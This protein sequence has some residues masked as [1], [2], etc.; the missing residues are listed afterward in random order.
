MIS[1]IQKYFQKHFK[2]VFLLILAAMAVPLIVIFTPS[3]G[4]GQGERRV[5]KQDFFGY[6]LGSPEDQ[7]R[8]FGDAQISAMLQLGYSSLSEDQLK[9]YALQRIA[10]LHLANELH[11]PASTKAE[12][13]DFI[14]NLRA[15]SGPDGNFDPQRYASFRDSLKS[16]RGL[17]EADVG[18]IIA[19]DVRAD[20]VRKLLAGPGYVLDADVKAQLARTGT[21]WTLGV[22]TV[23]YASFDPAIKPTSDQLAKFYGD[24]TFRYEV[25]PRVETSAVF[26]PAQNYLSQV[27]ATPEKLKAFFDA[28]PGRF[29]KPAGDA[30]DPK[31]TKPAG[32]GD[33]D[34]VKDQVELAYKVTQA[35]QLAVK[36]ASDFSLA[37][38]E[39]HL[40]HDQAVI[41]SFLA[42]QHLKEQ[43]LQP[44]TKEQGPAEYDHD[45]T[46]AKAAFLLNNDRFF[47]DALAV[48]T[49]AVVLLW[50]DTLPAYTPALQ[51]VL[52]QVTAD[53][54]ANEKRKLFVSTGRTIK[55]LLAQR[56]EA[57]DDFAKAAAAAASATS[58]K[59][60]T[61]TLAPFKLS[62]PPSDVDYS[63]FG[64]LQNLKQGQISD[65]VITKDHGLL[66]Y[67]ANEQLPDLTE[68]NPDFQKIRQQIAS[69]T[70]R[71]G[72]S[73]YLDELV[74]REL[75]K[76]EPAPAN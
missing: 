76:S 45:E 48:R 2:L 74:S 65:M 73:E 39:S 20:K 44:F 55:R 43:P 58:T 1:W 69:I 35:R 68:S 46:V 34:L 29:Q 72:A 3:S 18:R 61:K 14:K 53:Y 63:V 7:N 5:L 21:T 50:K 37:L 71:L 22:A 49:G 67:A 10:A 11:I 19:A 12:V 66:V 41:D 47:T 51:D 75:K 31:A 9:Q 25:P 57:G 15:F 16:G 59:I 40:K 42:A 32:P 4:I 13:T 28:A 70:S 38:Y 23:D 27:Q 56:L 24:N 17:T 52:A 6:N 60:E 8:V 36:A 33:Y 26:F 64:T 54:V 62:Q 30:K